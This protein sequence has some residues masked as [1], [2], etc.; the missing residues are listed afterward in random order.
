MNDDLFVDLENLQILRCIVCK[1]KKTLNII[2]SQ[3]FVLEKGLIKYNKINGLTHMKTHVDI[4][5]PR[6]FVLRKTQLV[7]KAII[8][9]VEH[10]WQRGKKR[11]RPSSSAITTYF[12]ST[13]PYK[14]NDEAYHMFIEDL[15][16]YICKGYR[17]LSIT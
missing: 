9:N 10:T 12:G 11:T 4:A 14:N 13:N 8:V 3:N 2:L 7:K 15:V 5:H 1:P 16:F 6:L 17:A